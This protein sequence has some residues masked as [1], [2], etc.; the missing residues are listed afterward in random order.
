MV[1]GMHLKFSD[2]FSFFGLLILSY[3]YNEDE[4][5][6]L[7]EQRKKKD[8]EKER[9]NNGDKENRAM[10]WA[11]EDGYGVHSCSGWSR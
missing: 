11:N 4:V 1:R 10:Y 3:K 7:R 5:R 9:E 6:V 8:L 2:I